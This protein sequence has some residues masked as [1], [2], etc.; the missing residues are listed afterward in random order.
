MLVR[1]H[2]GSAVDAEVHGTG[3][4]V[5]L[6]AAPEPVEGPKADE[7]RRW[8]ADPALGRR[9]IDGLTERGLRV[10]AFDYEGHVL[11][12]PKPDTLTPDNVCADIL[13]VADATGSQRFAWYGYSWTAVS[14]LQ[15]AA[16][17][18]RLTA[19]VM[20]GWPPLGAPYAAMLRVTTATHAMAVSPPAVPEQTGNAWADA[21]F[22]MPEPAARQFMTLYRGLRDFDERAALAKVTCPRLCVVGGADRITY[23]ERWGGVT[24]DLAAP[25]A[26]HRAELESMGWEVHVLDGLDHMGAMQAGTVLPILAPFFGRALSEENR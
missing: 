25:V 16:R 20:G 9:L 23:D 11:A 22:T 13:A 1:L 17:T 7:L 4:T 18:D 21:E 12:E 19:L 6:P 15:L 14:G 2:D 8:G 24:V 26:A 5:L 3:P 10:V